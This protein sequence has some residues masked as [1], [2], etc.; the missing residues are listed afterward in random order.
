MKK[1]KTPNG[2][3][4][5]SG[6]FYNDR[7]VMVFSVLAA[8]ILWFVVAASDKESDTG[9]TVSD[10]PIQIT[11]SESAQKDGL[12]IFYR[13]VEKASVTVKGNW[14]TVADI[15]K[16]DIQVVAK[17]SSTIDQPGTYSLQLTAKSQGLRT[18]Y[19]IVQESLEPQTITV[20]V[21]RLKEKEFTV[22]DNISYNTPSGYIGVQENFNPSK[23]TISG[24]ESDVDKIARV[25]AEYKT[26]DTLVD[27]KTIT[28]NLALYDSNGTQLPKADLE[29][30]KMSEE[31]VQVDISI[32]KKIEIPVRATFSNKPTG[33]KESDLV[34]VSPATLEV[35][36][37]E[38]YVN[39]LKE[40][41]LDTIDFST[42]TP[43]SGDIVSKIKLPTGCKNLSNADNATVTIDLSGYSVKEFQVP[44]TMFNVTGIPEGRKVS[45]ISKSVTVKVIGPTEEL[46]ALTEENFTAEIDLKDKDPFDGHKEVIV[47]VGIT[48]NSNCWIYKENGADY[49]VSVN[50]EKLP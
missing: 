17:Q 31:T 48:G 39:E 15:S 8:V 16:N 9:K 33:F 47:T 12:T 44:D 29:Y 42:L 28:A 38:K 34:I 1:N 6:L 25:V 30:V 11:L 10:I 46:D 41:Q 45:P 14:L 5:L 7:F 2:K 36:C 32:L 40:I 23:I 50:M 13:S 37:P 18:N 27:S 43:D 3:R 49:K 22:E 35:G 24:P 4:S 26:D 19:E 20:K 21:D